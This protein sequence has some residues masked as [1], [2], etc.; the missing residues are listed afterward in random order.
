MKRVISSLLIFGVVFTSSL[1]EGA[2]QIASSITAPSAL[3]LDPGSKRIIYARSPHRKQAAA[4]TTKIVTAL[5]AIESLPLDHW[6]RIH[7]AV[8]AIEPSKLYLKA[9]DELRVRDLLKAI[10]MKSANDAAAALAIEV[11][12]SEKAFAKK[13]TKAARSWGA[14][15][16]R[17]INSNGLPGKGQYST[18]YDLALIMQRAM[19]NPVIVSILKQKSSVIRTRQGKRFFLKSHNK[20]LWK[21]QA[22]IGKTGWTRTSKH[23]FLGLM[24]VGSREAIVSM[25]GSHRLWGDVTWLF[26]R[27]L[28]LMGIKEKR[29]LAHGSRGSEVRKLQWALKRA[30]YFHVKPTGYF[31]PKTKQSVLNF[32]KAKHLRVDGIAG[33][34]TIESLKSF[35]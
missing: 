3:L 5:V 33:P 23:C 32:Q 16:T 29:Y 8:E 30:G 10:L 25:L 13:M 1:A 31:G 12:G 27:F 15:N 35:Y 34:Q 21:Q 20:M 19:K 7:A 22:V 17:F 9:G 18:A 24:Q 26:D 14:K 6:V 2:A 4:S 28:R 11:S